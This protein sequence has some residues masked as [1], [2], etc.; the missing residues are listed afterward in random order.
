LTIA[1]NSKTQAVVCVDA[2]AGAETG[3]TDSKGAPIL[4][5]VLERQAAED[6]AH[7]IELMS[8]A[9]PTVVSDP[10]AIAAALVGD[11]PV[12][13]IGE[14][15]LKIRP[16]L[17]TR[18]AAV[19]HA[20]KAGFD[21]DAI[22]LL[23]D[24]NRVYLAGTN[25]RSHYYAVTR[26]LNLWGSRW[27]LPTEFG[28]CIP[29]R[30]TLTLGDLDE[31]YAPPFLVRTYWLSWSGSPEGRDDF[32]SRNFIQH[33]RI[34]CQHTLDHYLRDL[35]PEGKSLSDVSLTDTETARH[36][37][38][39]LDARFAEGVDFTLGM[40]DRVYACNTPADTAIQANLYDKH[41]QS[42]MLTDVIMTFHNN[43]ARILLERHPKSPS[44]ISVLAYGNITIPPQSEM[45]AA[46][47]L[48]LLLAPIDIDPNHG[49]D[50]IR[51]PPRR[52][53]GATMHRWSEIMDG[54]VL[55]YDYDQGMLV[56]RDLPNPSHQAFLQDVKHYRDAGVL[57]VQTESRGAMA[58]TFLNLHIRGQ[59]MWNPDLDVDALLAEFYPNFYGPA[60]EAMAAYWSAL[61]QA[62][63][64]T[65]V[66]EHE[67]YAIPAIYTESL[68]ETLR[69]HLAAAKAAIAP[70]RAREPATLSRNERHYLE[71]M[72]F[73]DLSFATIDHYTAMVRAAAEHCDYAAA[74]QSG[75]RGLAARDAMTAMS[76]IFTSTRH[77]VGAPWFVGETEQYRELRALTDGT[78]GKLIRLLPLDWPFLRDPHDTGMEMGVA[79][80]KPDLTYWNA[81]RKRY[82]TPAA[83][84]DYPTTEWEMIRSDRYAQSQGVLHP[85]W[86]SFTGFMW[87]KSEIEIEADASQGT[88][89]IHF[90]GLFSEAWLYV[91]GYLVAHRPQNHI[92]WHNNY[93]FDWDVDLTGRLQ[94]G[95]NDLTLRIH[96]THHNGGLFRR[97]FM[98]RPADGKQ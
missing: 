78:R 83:R 19:A 80:Q 34:T 12:F 33:E 17:R 44:R 22:T 48:I 14:L 84:K 70:L 16:E 15:A 18:L 50:D 52:E 51:S 60:A 38:D 87:Y 75:E 46:T 98:Y 92:W 10:D 9:H 89:H 62:W 40:N 24:A 45:R 56:W 71:R 25:T 86:Q 29:E 4:A 20:A 67:F 55:I 49:M 21:P 68:V 82:A 90:P 64:D 73:T 63:E 72:S 69:G 11:A 43:V 77:E 95:V 93:R 66:T 88:V 3:E 97:P 61:F 76:P 81:N 58:T 30:A 37:A 47:P 79:R 26:L 74:V 85:D 65:L 32:Q 59:L 96:N 5:R 31:T 23:R 7:Y 8:G 94:T 39:Q 13:V 35:V 53:F 54:R 57:G 2:G 6:L 28:E 1:R 27:Y 41:F 91:N 36:V 42:Q